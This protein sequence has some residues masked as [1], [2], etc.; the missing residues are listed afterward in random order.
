[1]TT[2][3]TSTPDKPDRGLLTGILEATLGRT[4]HVEIAGRVYVTPNRLAN[5]LGKTERT[6]GRWNAMR[7]G[8]P[9]IRV[10][11]LILYDLAK[12]PEWLASHETEP[13]RGR[14]H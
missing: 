8:P 6:L 9:K 1:M 3:T 12:I 11:K 2:T 4:G 7:C 10:G 5:T 14:R 13:V